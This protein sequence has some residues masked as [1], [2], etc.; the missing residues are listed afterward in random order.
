MYI[1]FVAFLQQD[2]PLL[3]VGMASVHTSV[4][5]RVAK[6]C[7]VSRMPSMVAVVSGRAI[8]YNDWIQD[9]RGIKNFIKRALPDNVVVKVGGE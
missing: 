3:G 1:I 4:Q 8:H 2:L 5:P 9:S 7:S 6:F